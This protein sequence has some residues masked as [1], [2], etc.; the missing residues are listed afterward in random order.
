[1]ID[2]PRRLRS[3]EIIRNLAAETKPDRSKLIMPY[4]VTEGTGVREGFDSMPGIDRVSIDNLIEDLKADINS[5]IEAILLF[6]I[7]NTKDDVGSGAY[8]DNGIIQKAVRKIRKEFKDTILIITDLCLCEYTDHG[9]C[10]IIERG[11]I[12][13]DPTVELLART[14]LSHAEAGADIVAPSDMMD[15]RVSA[16]RSVLEDKGFHNT[17][18]MAYSAKFCSS[19]YGPFRAVAGSAPSF[20]DRKSYQMDFRNGREAER[21]I[22]SDINEGADIIMIKPGLSYGDI[23]YRAKEI[24]PVPICVYNVSGEYSMVK[25]VSAKGFIDE[26]RIVTEIMTSFFRA[27]SDM[28]ISYHTRDIFKERWF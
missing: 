11:Q 5:G 9:H 12:V 28:I 19:F 6:G 15:G 20:G 2:R 22:I 13:N 27:G 3:N 23:I 8:S 24:S 21:E 14:A 4:F 26:K 10:G 7:P 17:A 18:I 1:M 16:I 25:T